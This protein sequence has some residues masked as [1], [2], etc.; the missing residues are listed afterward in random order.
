M[1]G[2]CAGGV[3]LVDGTK[4][5]KIVDSGQI[6]PLDDLVEEEDRR[7]RIRRV[8]GRAVQGRRPHLWHADRHNR[9]IVLYNKK[10]F[11]K[12]GIAAPPKTWDELMADCEN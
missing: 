1:S 7:R 9:W 12:A 4:L 11:D 5:A 8:G 3:Y 10:L 6:A 2:R